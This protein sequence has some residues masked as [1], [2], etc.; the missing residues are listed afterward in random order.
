MPSLGNETI[1]QAVNNASGYDTIIVR[2]GTYT[3]NV[4]VDVDNLT[5][6]SENGSANCVVNASDQNDLVFDVTADWVN[7]SGFTVRDATG[8][9]GIYLNTVDHCTISE[10]NVSNNIYGI[11]LVSQ[12]LNFGMI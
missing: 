5:I 6:R 4:N 2:D 8:A 10:N 9:L 3:E 1:Q 12:Q 11:Y 7:I